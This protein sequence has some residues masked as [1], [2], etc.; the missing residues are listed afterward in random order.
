MGRR[1]GGGG[2]GAGAQR[3]GEGRAGRVRRGAGA[4]GRGG[5][6]GRGEA[7]PGAR[8]GREL[9]PSCGLTCY[10]CWGA[11][12]DFIGYRA[13]SPPPQKRYNNLIYISFFL[14]LCLS[15]SPSFSLHTQKEEGAGGG[16][17]VPVGVVVVLRREALRLARPVLRGP[18]R[19]AGHGGGF[20]PGRGPSDGGSPRAPSRRR[21]RG[22]LARNG[23]VCGSGSVSV[24]GLS[25]E[26]PSR[27]GLDRTGP[28]IHLVR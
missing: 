25:G 6:W 8:L 21:H 22:H 26:D 7:V 23:C 18:P 3:R 2:R 20:T 13:V 4:V 10:C 17:A 9:G 19:T 14:P 1:R 11:G 24:S 28:G 12:G 15:V 27:P 16:G 5:L